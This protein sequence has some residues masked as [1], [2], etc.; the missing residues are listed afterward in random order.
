MGW[1]GER[2]WRTAALVAAVTVLMGCAEEYD[3][4][5]PQFERGTLGEELYEIWLKD[6]ARGATLPDERTALLEAHREEFITAVDRAVPPGKVYQLDR[7][8]INFLPVIEA[9][10][11]PALTRR[12]PAL[13]E[14]ALA[15]QA[16]MDSLADPPQYGA[17]DFVTHRQKGRALEE[18]TAYQD[19]PALLGHLGEV[20]IAHDGLDGEGQRDLEVPSSYADLLRALADAAQKEPKEQSSDRLAVALRDLFI[21]ADNRFRIEPDPRRSY[22]ALFDDRGL[23]KLR[24]DDTDQVRPPFVDNDGDG[25]ADV[26]GDGKFILDDGQRV[27]LPPL[28]A[29]PI[30]HPAFSRDIY[31]R[32]ETSPGQYVF[33]Y[34]DLSDTAIP[35]LVR[36]TGELAREGAFYHFSAA[37]R[38][39]LGP[40]VPRQD[41]RGAYLGYPDDHPLVDIVDAVVS[42]LAHSELPEVMELTARYISRSIDELAYLSH[43]VG[44]TADT[45]VDQPGADIYSNQTLLFDV[46]DILREI[47]ADP[48]L[49][50]DVMEALRDPILDRSGEAMGTL[51]RYRDA[52][53]VP[54]AD[55]PYDQCF[56][57][58]RDDHQI[59]TDQ[60]FDCI[61]SCPMDELFVDEMDFSAPESKS[62][63]SRFQRL[64]HLLR[65][66]AGV[67][68]VLELEE[69][70]QPWL[71]LDADTFPPIVSLPGAAEAFVRSVAGKLH[72]S[73]YISSEFTDGALGSLIEL[74]ESITGGAVDDSSV[75]QVLSV[76]SEL[77]GARLDP[78]PTPDQ[79][80]R[81]FNQPDLRADFPEEGVIIDVSNPV[82]KDG[83]VMAE[84]HA[85]GL[86]AAEASGLI[87]VLHPL[88]V[89]FAR[90]D[91]EELLTQLFMVIHDHYSSRDDLYRDVHGELSPMKASNLV[92][93]EPALLQIF[94]EGEIFR[95]L[96][97][98]AM[99]TENLSD[100]E[101]VSI[102]ER[103]RQ[104]VYQWVRND[105]G[106]QPLTEPYIIELNDGRQLD[107]L[108]RME[109]IFD[110][111][112]AMVDRVED[113]QQIIDHMTSAV[114]AFFEVVLAADETPDGDHVFRE[115]GVVALT[116]HSLRYMAQRAREMDE[117]GE[118]DPWLMED[119]PAAMKDFYSSRGFYAFVDLVDALHADEEGRRMLMEFPGHFAETGIRADRLGLA[120]Y[121]MIVQLFDMEALMPAGR[122]LIGAL[123]P[124]GEAPDFG[125][126][127]DLPNGTLIAHLLANIPQVDSQ[128]WG[129]DILA[130]GARPGEVDPSSWPVLAD[131][132]IRYFSP[133]PTA[134]GPLTRQAREAALRGIA[135]WIAD[136]RHGLERFYELVERRGNME[137][138]AWR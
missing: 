90:H 105:E 86:Y 41:A 65:D 74:L 127:R 89:A 66:T 16:L 91:R 84:H 44:E 8:L 39:M 88:T 69:L 118:L 73:D 68:Y 25:L 2:F 128:G 100:D 21:V 6:T 99:S 137:L 123:D 38:D 79:I 30:D 103:L 54:E 46:L 76:A 72:I 131:L 57:N 20:A 33:E 85:D 7:F 94:D 28:A 42:G 104:L 48:Q 47:A 108:S 71:E 50:A 121:A 77:F 126:H 59:G 67:E 111:F 29:D 45:V 106:Y 35:Y 18:A 52:V 102:D 132:L 135:Q 98:M 24:L 61:R 19:L 49:W 134:D 112:A 37:S 119:V 129:M 55:G 64:F 70:E 58:C 11:F 63:R 36:M 124:D 87:D 53:S 109:V 125:P 115:E 93:V 31:G 81:L 1:I 15:D 22:V 75:A 97:H 14:E 101:G 3:L 23:P 32:V 113:D 51:L 130:R 83:F 92:S 116:V 4:E 120:I 96:R 34:L 110:R 17:V 122:F 78:E 5:R 107:Q 13:V 114:E 26:D 27:S 95:A 56:Q 10:Y 12:V 40:P 43:V 138:E 136:D 133:T 82:C 80:T 62:N 60:R 117:R 9:G